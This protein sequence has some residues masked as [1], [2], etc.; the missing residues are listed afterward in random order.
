M[1]LE[2]MMAVLQTAAFPASPLRPN[3]YIVAYE[4][5]NLSIYLNPIGSTTLANAIVRSASPPNR[6]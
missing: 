4:E 1:G 3:S 6:R 5:I 2:P